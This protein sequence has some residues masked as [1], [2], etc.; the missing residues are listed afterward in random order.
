MG[1]LLLI[2]RRLDEEKS[3]NLAMAKTHSINHSMCAVSGL[4]IPNENVSCEID[5]EPL[6][7]LLRFR[8]LLFG[9]L[10]SGDEIK[11]RNAHVPVSQQ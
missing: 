3:R 8:L 9:C 6:I 2:A 5:G 4:T 11:R 7:I 1:K 10:M